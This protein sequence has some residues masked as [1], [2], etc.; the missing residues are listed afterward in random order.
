[1]KDIDGNEIEIGD[2]ILRPHHSR[3]TKHYVLGFCNEGYGLQISRYRK[4]S[5]WK[6][7][8]FYTQSTANIDEHNSKQYLSYAPYLFIY[9]KNATIPENLRKFVKQI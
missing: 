7:G 4:E 9:Q 2:I 5:A 1:M 8:Y 6:P 3:L